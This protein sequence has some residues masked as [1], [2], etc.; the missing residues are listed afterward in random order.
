MKVSSRNRFQGTVGRLNNGPIHCEVTIDLD[1]G[2]QLVAVIT[3]ASAKSLAVAQGK[4]AVALVKASLVTLLTDAGGYRFS[5][6]NQ[7][8]GTVS[9]VQKGAVNSEVKLRLAGGSEVCAVVTNE[10]V[11]ELQL[12]RGSEAT[13]LIK[14]SHVILAV[15]D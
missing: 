10:A 13:A 1:G 15:S 4:R 6:R 8:R 3:S 14:A 7:L 12:V 11:A 2:D 5:A 9:E